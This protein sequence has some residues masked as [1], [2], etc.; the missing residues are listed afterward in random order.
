MDDTAQS[1]P[2]WR[3]PAGRVAASSMEHFRLAA[4]AL[5]GSTVAGS[6]V[7]GSTVAG[8]PLADSRALHRWSVE[9][10]EQ[11]WGLLF[12]ELIPGVDRGAPAYVPSPD[13]H[14]ALA[15][16]FPGV[17]MNVA[18]IILGGAGDTRGDDAMFV[19][20]DERGR[21]TVTTRAEARAEVGR[22]AAA[23][24]ADGVTAGDRVV[25]WLPNTERAML[26]MLAAAS[27]GA[28][29]SSTSPDFG[30][31][32][33]LDRF[34]QI[35]PTV[36]VAADGYTYA[37]KPFDRRP[38]L[39]QIVAGL[40]TLRRAVLT[41]FLEDEPDLGPLAD[42]RAVGWDDWLT[43]HDGA[44]PEFA[45]LRFSHPWYVLFSSGTTGV[46]KC[47]VHRSGGVLLQHLKEH[48]LH[49][50]IRG[51]DNVC[52]FTTAGWM[53]W[54]WLASVPASGATA[55]LYEGS[56]FQP[57]PER[58][59]EL[60]ASEHLSFLGVS[61]K[62]IDAVAKTG[63]R[64]AESVD[65]G[66]LRTV[67]STGSPLS[68][69][70]FEWIYDAVA[71]GCGADGLHLAS[72]SGGTDLCG[73]F[74]CGDPTRP[75]FSGEIQGPALGMA[76]DVWDV[77]GLASA[78]GERGELVCTEVFPSTPLRFWDDGHG[79]KGTE[80]AS[81]PDEPE[82]GPRYSAA[83]FERFSGAVWAHG[84][85]ASW[86]DHGGIVIH[87]RSDTTLNPGG[88]RIGTAEIYRQ[89]EQ[90]PEVLESL[91]F[92]REVDGDTRIVL[93]VTLKDGTGLD[94]D[95]VADIRERIRTACTPRHV[96]AEILQI[97]DLPR[98]RSGKLAELAV[99]D[100][101]NGREVRNTSALANPATLDDIAALFAHDHA[102]SQDTN[103]QPPG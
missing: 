87:G 99:A 31:D 77:D 6:T 74:V 13:G 3:P 28:V 14:M 44:T 69:E 8:T 54:N 51:G 37:T 84:D 92:G 1:A 67:A 18:E 61:A 58:L 73:C 83:Y 97:P 29:F 4:E 43:P 40:P 70:S 45:Q 62:F 81:S 33:V 91:V 72:I 12:D 95:L 66:A 27:I 71:P 10:P 90:V 60:A 30:V 50:D 75:V 34:G 15:D 78:A 2:L 64:P 63:Y 24:R 59:W 89:V 85:F 21:R 96:P 32:G 46:P 7:A 68:P 17:R 9:R 20:L 88:V 38:E 55:V 57:G 94:E 11:F 86:T 93:L 76:V 22:I 49:C 103:R 42:S 36:L 56:P 16:W 19:S 79:G 80:T 25:V 82:V 47:I 26:V 48:R 35:E 65:L 102:R 41:G 52:Y 101:V 53:M 5:A 39:A 100:K 98:T 23:L